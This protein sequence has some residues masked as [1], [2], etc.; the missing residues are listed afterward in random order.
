MHIEDLMWDE[1]PPYFSAL[2][3]LDNG[4]AGYFSYSSTVR[5]LCW[6]D[7]SNEEYLIDAL[8]FQ[9]MLAGATLDKSAGAEQHSD[10]YHVVKWT[11]QEVLGLLGRAT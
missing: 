7:T 1:F 5:E 9:C 10:R 6:N 11:P 2:V 4:T 3:V 8:E